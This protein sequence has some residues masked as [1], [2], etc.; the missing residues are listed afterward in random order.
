[1]NKQTKEKGKWAAK[2]FIEK[3]ASDEDVAKGNSF[4]KKEI[5]SNILVNVGI[6]ALTTLLAGGG[7]TVFDNAN[8]FLGVGDDDTAA[9]AAQ[10]DLQ[11]VANKVRVAMNVSYP[12]FGTSQKITFQS[13]FGSAVANW[14]WKEMAVFNAAA[15]GTM[16][17][18][19]VS[20]Q[21][22]KTAGQTWRLSLEITIS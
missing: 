7:G 9:A 5:A 18:R 22:T 1:M 3:F 19:K 8:A 16:L 14:A 15:A 11:A 17:N 6:N 20:A 2:W 13:D 12:T 21:G 10:T 4:E